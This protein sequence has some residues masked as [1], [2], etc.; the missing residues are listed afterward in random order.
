MTTPASLD[1]AVFRKEAPAYLAEVRQHL[2]NELIPFWR[3]HGVD[4]QYGGFLTYLDRDG[5]PTGEGVKTLLCQCRMIYS[6]SLAHRAGYGD[7]YFLEKAKDGFRFV[8]ERLRG[9]ADEGYVWTA[10]RD[11]TPLDRKRILYGHSFVI[12]GFSELARALLEVSGE[13]SSAAQAARKAAEECLVTM[14]AHA[15]DLNYGGFFEFFEE[16]WRL[17]QPGVYGGDRKSLDVHM[18]LMEAFTSLYD[19]Q[20]LLGDASP[21]LARHTEQLINLLIEKM[22]DPVF[23]TGLAQFTPDWTPQR[24]ITFKN[25]WGSD[26]EADDPDGRPLD[27]TSY[28]HNVELGWLMRWSI[29]VLGL[30]PARYA[31]RIRRLYDHCLEYGIDWR[32]GGVF[33]EGPGAGP[34][35]ERNKEFWQQAETLVAMLDGVELFGDGRY[36]DAYKNVHR[37]AFDYMINHSV[38]EWRALLDENNNVVWD[39]MGHAWKINYHTMRSMIECE[40]R[41][42]RLLEGGGKGEA[43]A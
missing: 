38:G 32:K 31:G 5:H 39:Y 13:A 12:Y 27:N 4:E 9:S 22:L 36:W 20:K 1:N 16:D 25:V 37:F 33:C 26:R 7:G 3:T 18:H 40:K 14:L 19:L 8:Q 41:L 34:A 21:G 10:E 24:A 28:G 35:R 11:G 23:G 42:V 2:A 15:S 29:G 30:D 17:T 6:F 43:P